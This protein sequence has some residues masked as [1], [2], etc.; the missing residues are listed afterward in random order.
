MLKF[1]EKTVPKVSSKK[2]K[3]TYVIEI[4]RKG[5]GESLSC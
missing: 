3:G 2:E 4:M 5:R 1:I